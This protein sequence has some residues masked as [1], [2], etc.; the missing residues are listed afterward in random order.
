MK[1]VA[2]VTYPG[3]G[4]SGSG[5]GIYPESNREAPVFEPSGRALSQCCILERRPGCGVED[6]LEEGICLL[7]TCY[8][9]GTALGVRDPQK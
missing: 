9:L 6:A 4:D 8:M 1:E 2:R 7:S 5:A 3:P